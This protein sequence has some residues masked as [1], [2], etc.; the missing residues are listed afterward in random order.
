M[1][2][3]V[4]VTCRHSYKG[5]QAHGFEDCDQF[6]PDN[7]RRVRGALPEMSG[8]MEVLSRMLTMLRCVST[9]HGL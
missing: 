4:C 8:K 3:S 6:F 2:D 5:N 7:F 1:F 9:L